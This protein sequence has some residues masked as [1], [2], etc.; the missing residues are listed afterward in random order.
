MKPPQYYEGREQTYLKHFFLENY[1]ERVAYIIGYSHPQFVYVDGFSGPWKSADEAFEDTSF[2]IAIQKLRQ[3]KEGLRRVGKEPR[4][5]CLFIEKDRR[6][7]EDLQ[8]AIK[9]VTDLE[10]Q[11]LNGEFEA[12]IPDVLRFC[13]SS[14]S[15][16]FID[17][18]GWT[19]FGLRKIQA[20]L[21][22]RRGEVL[23]NFMFD[24]I[25]RFLDDPRPEI[26][27]TFDELF[28]G[29][30]WED[31]VRQGE[32]REKAIIQLYCDR[33]RVVGGFQHV[34][35]TRI[36]KPT[37]DR[38]YFY[39]VYGTRHIKGLREFRGIERKTV[40]EQERIRL[41][42][43]QQARVRR[44]GQAELFDARE[45][46][47]LDRI[48]QKN[49]VVQHTRATERLRT[50]LRNKRRVRFEVVLGTLLEMPLIWEDDIQGIVRDLRDAGELCIAGMN[51]RERK[52]KEHHFLVRDPSGNQNDF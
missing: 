41:A 15:L 32:G 29:P 20:I 10:I 2:I 26:A 33:L 13:G 36:L 34:T 27:R 16:I 11:V 49:R 31:A 46:P 42:A 5:R 38:S 1:L 22:R 35:S 51:P 39:L 14:F 28:G 18:T 24:H 6:A 21:Q 23:V 30:G 43:K 4:V 44:T 7:F 52:I 47:S 19:G 48:F 45:I 50:L 17:P 9:E 3:V 25:N 12:L 40:A 37:A 8:R